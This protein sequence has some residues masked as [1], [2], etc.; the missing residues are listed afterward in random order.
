M[1]VLQSS[2][3][4]I[5]PHTINSSLVTVASPSISLVGHHTRVVSL[6]SWPKANDTLTRFDVR[7]TH[8]LVKYNGSVVNLVQIDSISIVIPDLNF[9]GV[10]P[11]YESTVVKTICPACKHSGTNYKLMKNKTKQT[12]LFVPY[13]NDINGGQEKNSLGRVHGSM[14]TVF[15]SL[16]TIL[17]IR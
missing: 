17:T 14:V 3:P 16:L 13:I 6:T 1:E 5:K 11:H 9:S 12:S 15:S 2:I 4:I 10:G 7:V 8:Q